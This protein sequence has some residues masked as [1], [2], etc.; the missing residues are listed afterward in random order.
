[1][2]SIIGRVERWGALLLAVVACVSCSQAPA[3]EGR[4]PAPP[5]Q[6]VVLPPT[7]I[8]Q[9]PPSLPKLAPAAEP[10]TTRTVEI[11]EFDCSKQ[12]DFQPGASPQASQLLSRWRAGG[13]SGASWNATDLKCVTLVHAQ[14]ARGELRFELLIGQR[15]V[16]QN[17]LAIN[18][19]GLQR[20]E[21]EVLERTWRRELDAPRKPALPYR[22]ALLTMRA[23]VNCQEPEVFSPATDRYLDVADVRTFVA[24]FASGE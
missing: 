12:E 8:V 11:T 14:C 9:E 18:T 23:E 24:G 20:A 13:P 22:T 17:V 7:S 6:S 2:I 5:Q 3:Q 1:M 21:F 10:K 15:A 16:A 4:A 19:P